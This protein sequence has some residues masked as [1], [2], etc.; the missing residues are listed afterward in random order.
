MV[1]GL[2][3]CQSAGSGTLDLS[4]IQVNCFITLGKVKMGYATWR[5]LFMYQT[6]YLV[7]P[8]YLTLTHG[9]TYVIGDGDGYRKRGD[10]LKC[11]LPLSLEHLHEINSSG[12]VTVLIR[13]SVAGNTR[14]IKRIVSMCIL[15]L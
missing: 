7:E 5:G 14:G 15:E 1:L 6:T 8:V 2:T 9:Y 4:G 13:G 11:C 12:D 3:I 10:H